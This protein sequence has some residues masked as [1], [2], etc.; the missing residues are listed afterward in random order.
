MNVKEEMM[1]RAFLVYAD[2]SLKGVFSSFRYADM[3]CHNEKYHL[4]PDYLVFIAVF[5]LDTTNAVRI[6][7]WSKLK[8][9]A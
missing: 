3:F 1:S 8:K 9:E 2:H 6:V 4:N 7:N 5:D